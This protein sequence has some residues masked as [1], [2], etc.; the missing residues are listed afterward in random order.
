MRHSDA[1]EFVCDR[2][3]HDYSLET[4]DFSDLQMEIRPG[5]ARPDPARPDPT[6]PDRRLTAWKTIDLVTFFLGIKK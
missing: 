3:L 1:R 5:P 4:A 2:K 6:R